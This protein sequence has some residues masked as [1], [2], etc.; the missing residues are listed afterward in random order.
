MSTALLSVVMGVYNGENNLF[1]TIDSILNQTYT[2]FEF[3]IINDGST[4][5][6]SEILKEYAARDNRIRVIEQENTGLTKALIRGCK[7]AQGKYI[8]RQDAGDISLPTRFEKQLKLLLS[9]PK[10]IMCSCWGRML[11]PNNEIL[12]EIKRPIDFEIA[13]HQLLYKLQP[14]NCC[15]TRRAL[16]ITE[17]LCF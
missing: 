4:D 3:I 1:K 15:I 17:A 16:R 10:L 13:T 5:K 9:N 12:T 8:A 6:T 7:E 14:T 2:D 11:G